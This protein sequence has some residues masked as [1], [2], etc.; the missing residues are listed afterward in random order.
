MKKVQPL[1]LEPQH[2]DDSS[3]LYLSEQ[4]ITI[5]DRT[6]R[7]HS[8]TIRGSNNHVTGN[9]NRVIGR[10]NLVLGEQCVTEGKGNIVV[11]SQSSRK[12]RRLRSRR[13]RVF[14]LPMHRPVALGFAKR[15]PSRAFA[16]ILEEEGTPVSGDEDG[17]IICFERRKDVLFRP[18]RHIRT[19]APCAREK[20]KED[21]CPECNQLIRDAE[22]V[23]P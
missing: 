8:N 4:T 15:R 1:R 10:N 22:I 23:Y 17:C 7:G 16:K 19:C 12:R 11:Q 2:D 9:N 14:V 6:I 21:R 3:V 5:S 18:C 13:R 20:L